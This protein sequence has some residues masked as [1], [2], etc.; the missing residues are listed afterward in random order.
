MLD[1]FGK[2]FTVKFIHALYDGLHQLAAGKAFLAHPVGTAIETAN[3][4]AV[5]PGQNRLHISCNW[6]GPDYNSISAYVENTLSVVSFPG[7]R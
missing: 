3:V 6:I 7:F 1:L 4:M 2:I 5:N